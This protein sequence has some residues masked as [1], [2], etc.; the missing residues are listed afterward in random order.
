[1]ARKIK[2]NKNMAPSALLRE[3][4]DNQRNRVENNR[5]VERRRVNSRM[6]AQQALRRLNQL[7]AENEILVEKQQFLEKELR[8]LK[9]LFMAE[10]ARISQIDLPKS[11]LNALLTDTTSDILEN[12]LTKL[13]SS[14]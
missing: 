13:Q 1:M 12:D 11:V 4:D 10:A 7:R 6:R 14:S 2:E 3:E 8:F 5:A 9:N